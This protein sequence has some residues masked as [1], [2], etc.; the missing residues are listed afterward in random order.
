MGMSIIFNKRIRQG[1][2][3]LFIRDSSLYK[4]D[5]LKLYTRKKIETYTN[6]NIYDLINKDFH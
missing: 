2:K 3:Y 1:A 6:V 5:Y 4:N